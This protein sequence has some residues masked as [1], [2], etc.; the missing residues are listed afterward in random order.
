MVS[1][2]V[3]TRRN[4]DENP[5]CNGFK[6]DSLTC[7]L[8][9]GLRVARREINPPPFPRRRNP[10]RLPFDIAVAVALLPLR[11]L[12]TV[13]LYSVLDGMQNVGDVRVGANAPQ[14]VWKPH[15]SVAFVRWPCK[16]SRDLPQTLPSLCLL[17]I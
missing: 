4:N 14:G 2:T 16:E 1:P 12:D 5:L 9:H 3:D 8:A 15:D 7:H 13:A 6:R 10:L 17:F 11:L